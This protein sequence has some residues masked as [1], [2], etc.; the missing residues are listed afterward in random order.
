VLDDFAA[1]AGLAQEQQQPRGR[2]AEPLSVAKHVF[3][4][5][6]LNR[7]I[8]ISFSSP[9]IAR[10]KAAVDLIPGLHKQ[11]TPW[12]QNSEISETLGTAIHLHQEETKSLT[13]LLY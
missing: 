9:N 13:I 12:V 3:F 5:L 11:I 1:M 6:F 4:V 7:L 8:N 2:R 10:G